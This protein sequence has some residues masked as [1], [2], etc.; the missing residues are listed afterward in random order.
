MTLTT[1]TD[2]QRHEETDAEE[3]GEGK[4]RSLELPG[5][6]AYASGLDLSASLIKGAKRLGEDSRGELWSLPLASIR[7]IPR[8]NLRTPTAKRAQL[9][10]DLAAAL[11]KQGYR[12]D[13]PLLVYIGRSAGKV[14]AYLVDGHVR[15]DAINTLRDAAPK[16]VPTVVIAPPPSY[17][18]ALLATATAQDGA[19][20]E[21]TEKADLC[22]R[23]RD[24]GVND[25][26]AADALGVT[27]QYVKD[28]RTLAQAPARVIELVESGRIAPTT[29]VQALQRHG[30]KALN[31]ITRALQAANAKGRVTRSLL[32]DPIERWARR[33]AGELYQLAGQIT[34]DSSYQ[35]ISPALRD[36]L[37]QLL[38][39]IAQGPKRGGRRT[40]RSKP[41]AARGMGV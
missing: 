27:K 29:A 33:H 24:C 3:G 6:A 15:L 11:Q 17:A 18:A 23:L 13:K 2:H 7:V 36:K 32:A 38:A 28:L 12:A 5:L 21:V 39:T 19:P 41:D 10:H 1:Y 14:A 35:A 20:L 22:L 34:T 8:F 40:P 9:V 30:D 37:D 25:S 31:V 16:A 26:D 4:R